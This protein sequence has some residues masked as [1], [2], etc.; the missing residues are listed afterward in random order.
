VQKN[1]DRLDSA[2]DEVRRLTERLAM[3]QAERA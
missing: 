1:R 2:Q 3:L